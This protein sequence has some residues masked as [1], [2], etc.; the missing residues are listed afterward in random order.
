MIGKLIER[1][2]L[3]EPSTYSALGVLF[4]SIGFA[5]STELAQTLGL[6]LAGIA[7]VIG[8]LVKESNN[9]QPEAKKAKAKKA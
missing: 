5:V 3:T 7:G 1:L 6:A 9:K 4:G 2:N 8:V